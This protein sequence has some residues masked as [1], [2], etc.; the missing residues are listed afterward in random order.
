MHIILGL[1]GLIATLVETRSHMPTGFTGFFHPA[2]LK[3]DK[4]GWRCKLGVMPVLHFSEFETE[5]F[6]VERLR[7]RKVR[8]V[9]LYTDE[10]EVGRCHRRL[11]CRPNEYSAPKI[12]N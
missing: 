7:S 1:A 4:A 11:R 2:A 8:K 3:T 12:C 10:M 6:L 9:E 5:N